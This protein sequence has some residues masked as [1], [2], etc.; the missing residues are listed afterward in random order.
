M[1][2]MRARYRRH[3][4]AD[5]INWTDYRWDGVWGQAPAGP[6]GHGRHQAPRG[7][8]LLR[9]LLV[10]LGIVLGARLLMSLRRGALGRPGLLTVLL[11][12]AGV[13]AYSR[14]DPRSNWW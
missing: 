13:V 9:G 14:R 5:P 7:G 6:R 10:V 1:S 8:G 2:N 4:Y 3:A 11:V 12:L